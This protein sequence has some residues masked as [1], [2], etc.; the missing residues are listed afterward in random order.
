VLLHDRAYFPIH[1]SLVYGPVDDPSQ[2]LFLPATLHTHPFADP[3]LV[4]CPHQ[5]T[6]WYLPTSVYLSSPGTLLF[7][8][9]PT[10]TIIY[11]RRSSYTL[12]IS[13]LGNLP[14]LLLQSIIDRAVTQ[15]T[16]ACC[17]TQVVDITLM[18]LHFTNITSLRV[19]QQKHCGYTYKL[20]L[21]QAE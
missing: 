14:P 6:L 2:S 21:L 17:S 5:S 7:G 12:V 18:K 20:L 4:R 9:I 10:S 16:T 13:D 3:T 1:T 19:V 11:P 8:S 15:H